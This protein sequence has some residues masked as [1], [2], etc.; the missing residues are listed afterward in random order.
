MWGD[1]SWLTNEPS[2]IYTQYLRDA[3]KILTYAGWP[4]ATP[5]EIFSAAIDEE[6]DLKVIINMFNKYM[7]ENTTISPGQMYVPEAF[8][9]SLNSIVSVAA[10][11]AQQTGQGGLPNYNF[12][13][14]NRINSA[15]LYKKTP[16]LVHY[17]NKD[18]VKK[19]RYQLH[20]H[21]LYSYE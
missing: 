10:Q 4:Q 6:E 1:D 2:P 5:Q 8:N 18:A 14:D 15:T 19:Q 11:G 20:L 9:G 3:V 17:T 13:F 16:M 12:G 7:E 21:Q